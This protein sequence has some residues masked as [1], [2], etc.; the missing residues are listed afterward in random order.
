[1][2]S[3]WAP[4][5]GVV[6]TCQRMARTKT[7]DADLMETS[8]TRCLSTLDLTLLGLGGMVGSGL[9]V[10]TGTVAKSMA[11]PAVIISFLLAGLASMLAALCYAEFGARAPRA[12][13]AYL[14]TYMTMGEVWAFMIGWNVV[15]EYMIGGAAVARAWSG[16]FDAIFE[17]KIQN[18]TLTHVASWDVPFLAH[19]PDFLACGILF[20]ATILVSF[21]TKVSSWI[22]HLFAVISMGAILF[23]LVFGFTL[24]DPQNYS[25]KEGGFAPYGFSGIMTGTA[26]CFFAFVGFDVIASSSEEARDPSRS[27]PVATALSL[28]LATLA[29]TLVAT[30]LTL[31][32]P[33]HSLVPESALSDA[34]SRR[35]HPWAG[36]IVSTGSICA[37]NTVLLSSLF[38]LPRIIYAMADDG[39]FFSVFSHLHAVTKVPVNAIVVFGTLTAVLATLFDLEALVQFLSIGTLL[40][41]TFVAASVIVLRYQPDR[42]LQSEFL[43]I[44]PDKEGERRDTAGYESF[45]DKLRLVGKQRGETEA[46]QAGCLKARFECLLRVLAP[47]GPGEAVVVCVVALLVCATSLASMLVFGS[48]HLH[49]PTWAFA[50]FLSIFGLGFLVSVMLIAAHEQNRGPTTFLVPCVPFLPALS[51]LIN[52]TLMLKLNYMT[53]VRFMVW[54]VVGMF[55]Y[56]SYG[57]WHSKERLREPAPRTVTARYVVIPSGRLSESLQPVQPAGDGPCSLSD[58]DSDAELDGVSDRQR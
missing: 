58:S 5:E 21:G 28:V 33:W 35:G 8:L 20:I 38:S 41:Y 43:D 11:G 40:A 56:L 18:F 50:L 10:L 39:L 9:Y 37:M 24:A 14:Y 7:L 34:F 47:C 6:R 19:Y 23:I 55:I 15:L 49:L 48:S 26:T 42:T 45:S 13:S 53:W 1:M 16:Y 52:I 46:R 36:F 57:M 30:V 51:M 31:M 22:N 17:H 3:R 29:Y 2:S 27:V 4:W 32:V 44:S 25:K 54:I 12:G